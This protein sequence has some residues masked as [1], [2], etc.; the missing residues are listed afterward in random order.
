M[1]D[2]YFEEA[3]KDPVASKGTKLLQSGKTKEGIEEL[4]R[5]GQENPENWYV[6][7]FLGTALRTRAD[8]RV[9]SV[10]TLKRAAGLKNV[11]TEYQ[12]T[13]NISAMGASAQLEQDNAVLAAIKM[14]GMKSKTASKCKKCGRE[15]IT[16]YKLRW[17][18]WYCLDCVEDMMRE[19][20]SR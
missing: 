4:K 15:D 20:A 8:T 7:F 12:N 3:L 10:E 18:F 14:E 1:L 5:A 16:L 6:W 17:W 13:A 9:E 2:R 19:E 11:G